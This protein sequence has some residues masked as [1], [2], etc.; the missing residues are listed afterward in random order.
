MGHTVFLSDCGRF[1]GCRVHE[2]VT[3]ERARRF[4]ED[5]VAFGKARR[6]TLFLYDVR[7]ARN[8]E[9]VFHN[10]RFANEDMAR[11]N[12][13]RAGS[14]AVVTDPDDHSH[15]FVETA[16]RNAGYDVRMFGD[17]DSAVC[18]LLTRQRPALGAQ[19]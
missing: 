19:Q 2:D 18:W 9:T 8:I 6:I 7:G 14:V 11:L 10:Y 15:D 17:Y 5:T 13:N 1:V 3:I 16:V 4:T 12:V